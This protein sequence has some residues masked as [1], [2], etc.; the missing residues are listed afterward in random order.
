[1]TYS[2]FENYSGQYSGDWKNNMREGVGVMSYYRTD[3]NYE[4]EWKNDKK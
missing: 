3:D 4:G 1:M 2:F